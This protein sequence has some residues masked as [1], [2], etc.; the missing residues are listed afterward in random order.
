MPRV[1]GIDPG[2]VTIDVCGL[3]DGRVFLDESLSAADV[4][5][6]PEVLV[7]LLAD[8]GPFDLIAGPSGYGLPL[9]PIDELGER[10]LFLAFLARPHGDGGITGLRALVRRLRAARLPVIFTPGVIHLPTVP[11]HRKVNRIDLG[12][13]DK[14]C[15]AALAIHDQ[16][17]RLRVAPAETSFILVE[18]GGAFTAV[19]A[20][21]RGQI[22][23]GQG[24]S[25]GPLGY[26][27][28][29]ALDGEL[30]CLLGRVDK[31]LVFSGGAAAVAG[32]PDSPPEALAG[33]QDEAARLARAALVE[34]VVKAVA[35][36]AAVVPRP[37]E[38]LLSGRLQRVSG[39][40]EPMNEALAR[41]GPVRPVAGFARVAKEA[42]QGAALL[43]D[44]LAAG[45]WCDLVDTLHLR[46]ASGTSLD[47]LYVHGAAAARQSIATWQGV[48]AGS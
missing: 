7:E 11:P 6:S 41:F 8:T 13:A 46:E 24:G 35:A 36:A 31:A 9:L 12:T 4:A 42:A 14:V 16:A 43:A 21:D 44:G 30:A 22:V 2:T 29:G 33:R 34:G 32:A 48:P 23:D 38:I 25:S 47:H 37:R 5:R 40:I 10:E 20:V 39:L 27:A 3:E 18:L 26:R 28:C 45:R 15:A 19:L 17:V 1:A